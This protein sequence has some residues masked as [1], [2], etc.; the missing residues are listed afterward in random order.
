M[1][2]FFGRRM[3]NS[4][5]SGSAST[6]HDCVPLYLMSTRRAPSAT[7]RSTLGV[8]ALRARG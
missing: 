1:S 2:V 7:V 6:V 4:F 8:A 5:L 3:Q